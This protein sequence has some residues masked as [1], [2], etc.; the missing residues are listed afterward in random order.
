ME[1]PGHVPS[2][3]VIDYDPVAGPEVSAHPPSAL[4]SFRDRAR[5]FYTPFGGGYWVP[6][7]YEDIAAAFRDTEMFPQWGTVSANW[8]ERMHIPLRLNP[9][10]HNPYKKMLLGMFSPRR[11]ARLEPL[12]RQTARGRLAELAPDGR[13]ELVSSFALALPAATFC[14]LL[15]LPPDQFPMFN[16]LSFE[17]VYGAER[18]RESEGDEAA[19]A[20]RA[21]IMSTIEG[22]IAGLIPER[23]ARRGTDI[24]SFLLDAT[25]GGRSLTEEEILNIASL[26]FFAGTDSTGSLIAYSVAY[27]AGHQEAKR[28]LADRP[29]LIPPAA[30]ELARFHGFHHLV[31]DVAADGEFAG[32]RLCRGDKILLHTGGA[33]HDGKAF[34]DA[35][36]V[37]LE[38]RPSR[39]LTFGTGI[40]R[41]LGAPLAMLELKVALEELLTVIPDFGLDP[42]GQVAYTGGQSKV[43]PTAVPLVFTPVAEVP[44]LA[45]DADRP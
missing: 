7:R 13:C 40:H 12:I 20:V 37:D 30:E 33:N 35:C 43:I 15:G 44:G 14:G 23:Q 10:E 9:P 29:E 5:I 4:D 39:H 26:L 31:R 21:R 36:A 24:I 32:V 41:C 28:V 45:T 18:V 2:E 3:L 17:L 22:I 8:T 1:L 11:V 16:G 42:A 38:R 27:L 25:V 34:P 6:T 19:A